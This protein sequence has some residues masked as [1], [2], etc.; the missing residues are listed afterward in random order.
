MNSITSTA[1]GFDPVVFESVI[2]TLAGG[3]TLDVTGY[4]NTD[5]IIPAG[6]PVTAKNG[7]TGLSS[8]VTASGATLTGTA[9]GY[10]HHT[11]RLV[12][13]GNNHVGVV[14][15]GV[16]RGAALPAAYSGA[17]ATLRTAVPKVNI[18]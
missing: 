2:D 17:L 15:G 16:A 18:V 14:L 12:A 11:I 9:I 13:G 3:T 4:T 6:T 5:G 10:V 7:T 1:G 8:I